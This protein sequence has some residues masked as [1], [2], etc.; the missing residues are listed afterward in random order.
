MEIIQDDDFSFDG[1]QVVRGEF[2]AHIYE[3]S[4]TF[5]DCK[6]YVNTACIKKLPA[7]DYIQILVNPALKKLAVRPCMESEKDS[8]RWCSMTDKRSPRHITCR[9]FFA[10]VCSLMGWRPTDRYRI[11]GKLIQSREETLFVFDL[12]SPE[13]YKRELSE[14]GKSKGTRI[15][16]YPASWQNQFG[17][18]VAEHQ[19]SLVVNI[20]HEKA[21]FGLEKDPRGTQEADVLSSIDTEN[22]EMSYE[23]LSL[24]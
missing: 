9:I 16:N 11:L 5:A 4:I 6:V 1:F 23:Q 10:K 22:T 12:S 14:D 8:F 3:P 15:P 13:V 18:P 7:Y 17:L 2:F 19:G 20:F 24:V 21:V